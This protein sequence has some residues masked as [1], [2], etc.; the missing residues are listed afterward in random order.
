MLD[1]VAGIEK[2]YAE[3]ENEL[4]KPEVLADQEKYT[5]LAKEFS[6]MKEI[7][8]TI[9]ALKDA[10]SRIN[11]SEQL[12]GEEKDAEMREFITEEAA[13]AAEIKTQ[14]EEKLKILLLPQDPTDSKNV[15]M[16]IRAGAGGEEAALFAKDV[17]RMYARFA[18]D[19]KWKTEVLSVSE[20]DAGGFKEIVFSVKGA[21]V[22][23]TLKYESGV[24]RVQRIPETES[25]GRIHTST[26]TVAVMPEVDDVEVN[27]DPGD[28]KIDTYRSSGAGGQHVNVTDSAVRITH[29]PTGLVV[30]CQD[31]RSQLQNREKAMRVLRARLYQHA[32]E[33]QQNKIAE[34]RRTQVG[35]GDRSEKIRTY[36]YPQNRI[37]DHRINLTVHN[38]DQVMEGDIREIMSAL[39]REDRVRKLE[40]MK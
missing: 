37:T 17:Y 35:T 16:E 39:A 27:I 15:I 28:L 21:D 36:N 34:N 2:R 31:E 32:L 5:A 14:L 1:K 33:T 3:I 18:E 23:G 20:G 6:G 22:Y 26:A 29:L 38:L 9:R 11:E 10:V 12:L 13:E 24:H 30:S 7:M 4:A 25:G 8:E 40:K 19:N